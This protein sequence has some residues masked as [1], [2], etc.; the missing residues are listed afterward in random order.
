M[1]NSKDINFVAAGD[2]DR[3]IKGEKLLNA[4]GDASAKFRKAEQIDVYEFRERHP[5]LDALEALIDDWFRAE[6]ADKSAYRIMSAMVGRTAIDP[7]DY[8]YAMVGAVTPIPIADPQYAALSPPEYFMRV[9]EQ[10][11]DFSFLYS[12][13]RR[14]GGWR[15]GPALLPIVPWS[16]DGRRQTGELQAGSL[17]LHN[18]ARVAFGPLDEAARA[19]IDGWLTTVRRPLPSER[20]DAVRETLFRAGFSG[21]GEYLETTGG[22]FFPQHPP[23]NAGNGAVFIATDISFNFGAPG[24]LL[25]PNGSETVRFRDVGV[26]VGQATQA[27]ETVN[28]R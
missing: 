13:D 17:R 12:S 27:K 20:G 19:F 25:D 22:L 8:F 26:F 14:V 23:G 28:I 21:C 4:I 6:L 24:L 1:A 10:K 7:D 3:P 18:M 16:S 9:C 5:R 15:P 2:Q 11:G